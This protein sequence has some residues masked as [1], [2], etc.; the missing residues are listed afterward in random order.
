MW[1]SAKLH[2]QTLKQLTKTPSTSGPPST[3][4]SR[5]MITWITLTKMPITPGHS[6]SGINPRC[7]KARCYETKERPQLEYVSTLWGPP[8]GKNVSKLESVQCNTCKKTSITAKEPLPC[9]KSLSG[10]L[11]NAGEKKQ[12]SCCHP[13]KRASH[14]RFGHDSRY[15]Q[16]YTRVRANKYSF[17]SIGIWIWNG[18]VTSLILK[19]SL[20]IFIHSVKR[21]ELVE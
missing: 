19:L 12:R 20:E 8:T 17:I 5:W 9:W 3:T 2:G 6:Y 13:C 18:L 21:V 1:H 15:L 10:W 7:I 16:S 11:S 4:I 14:L